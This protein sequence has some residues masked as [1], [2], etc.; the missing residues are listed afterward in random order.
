MARSCGYCNNNIQPG[1]HHK[2][3][4]TLFLPDELRRGDV[5]KLRFRL[6]RIYVPY[7]VV[8]A[9]PHPEGGQTVYATSSYGAWRFRW[10]PGHHVPNKWNPVFVKRPNP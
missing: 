10:W 1:K 9:K 4:C 3:G 8:E 6:A 2:P 5:V 7:T